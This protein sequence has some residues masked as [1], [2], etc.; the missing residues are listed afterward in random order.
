MQLEGARRVRACVRVRG[1]DVVV[2]VR[3]LGL[4]SLV[5]IWFVLAWQTRFFLTCAVVLDLEEPN[6]Q[7][8][9][10]RLESW[11]HLYCKMPV[12]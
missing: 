8:R 11:S 9:P 3:F 5:R 6:N 12:L 10:G 4:M 2:V 7:R 1:V